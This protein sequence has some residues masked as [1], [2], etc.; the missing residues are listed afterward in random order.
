[1]A[2]NTLLNRDR[3]T[4]LG[5]LGLGF[6]LLIAQYGSGLLSKH[7][8]YLNDLA[9]VPLTEFVV[10]QIAAGLVFLLGVFLLSIVRSNQRLLAIA[11]LIV[12][13]LN[14]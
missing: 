6:T 2:V 1:M 3:A 9:K 8:S 7:F 4:T 14:L 13:V 10:L 12:S 5:L 11:V